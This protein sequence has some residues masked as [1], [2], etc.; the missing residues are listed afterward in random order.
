EVNPVILFM[1]GLCEEDTKAAWFRM[2]IN[3]P[4]ETLKPSFRGYTKYE[5]SLIDGNTWHLINM[6]LNKSVAIYFTHDGKY[7]FGINEWNITE[8]YEICE[9][10]AGIPHKLSLSA[11]YS[12]EYTCND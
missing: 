3:S 8:D 7:P 12:W 2:K 4:Q 11:C 5:I 9:K 6:W 1:R 10:Q